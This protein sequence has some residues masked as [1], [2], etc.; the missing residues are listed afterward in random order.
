M[1]T[2]LKVVA[3]ATIITICVIVSCSYAMAEEAEFYPKLT[4]ITEVEQMGD[5]LWVVYG[6]DHNG[7]QWSFYDDE[8][9]WEAGD[10]ANLMMWNNSPDPENHEVIEVYF[11]GHLGIIGWEQ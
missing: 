2:M 1:K 10:L 9:T 11:E 3:I 5:E 4:I 7:N 6:I 8:G